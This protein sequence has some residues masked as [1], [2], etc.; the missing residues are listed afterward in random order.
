M[1][2]TQEHENTATLERSCF[3]RLTNAE[4]ESYKPNHVDVLIVVVIYTGLKLED[5]H[6]VLENK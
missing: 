5:L 2:G 3:S 6:E 4:Q 1:W